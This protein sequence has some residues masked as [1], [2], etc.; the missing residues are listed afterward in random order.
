MHIGLMMEC[1]YREGWTQ[2][3]AFAEALATSDVAEALGFDG[4]WLTERHFS[5]PW[6]STPVSSI[7]SAPMLIATA[8]ATRTRRLRRQA[9]LLRCMPLHEVCDQDRPVGRVLKGG[10]VGP[11]TQPHQVPAGANG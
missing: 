10:E 4:I 1:D 3:E 11:E 5:P 9:R 7:G 6:G 2:Q 8:I